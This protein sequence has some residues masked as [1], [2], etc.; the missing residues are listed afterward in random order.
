M[1]MRKCL[2]CKVYTFKENCP[3]CKAQTVFPNP[4]KF[5]P[6][7]KYGELRRSAKKSRAKDEFPE[8]S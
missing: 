5:S 6:Q 3:K 7:D 1:K 4:P 8:T 2:A